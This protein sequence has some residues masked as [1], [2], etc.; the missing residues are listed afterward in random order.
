MTRQECQAGGLSERVERARGVSWSNLILWLV[1][2]CRQPAACA[3]PAHHPPGRAPGRDQQVSCCPPMVN[4]GL[5]R[6]LTFCVTPTC[7]CD[8]THRREQESKRQIESLQE[9]L[10]RSTEAFNLYR[11]RA[12]TALKKTAVE[13]HTAED[14]ISVVRSQLQEAEARVVRAEAE[15][16]DV[17][18]R[19]K[20][21][22]E[23]AE[24]RVQ[25]ALAQVRRMVSW[26]PG[27]REKG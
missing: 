6:L 10:K 24:D 16:A 17:E 2:M 15:K 11:A 19:L 1:C 12:H 25:A 27:R 18:A 4:P 7:G 22:E 13:Q 26:K 3:P 20:V 23:E 5:E 21:M 9:E 8:G 14:R